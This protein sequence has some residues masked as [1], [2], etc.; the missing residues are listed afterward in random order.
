MITIKLPYKTTDE[1]KAKILE[2][3]KEQNRLFGKAYQFQKTNPT[4]KEMTCYLNQQNSTLDS[5]FIQSAFYEGKAWL[6]ADLETYE[7]KL[8]DWEARKRK[9]ISFKTTKKAA[10][11]NKKLKQ[12]PSLFRVFGGNKLRKDYNLGKIS[13]DQYQKDKLAPISVVGESSK[14]GNRKFCLQIEKSMVIFKP[15]CGLKI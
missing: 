6:K 2:I 10:I 3:Q 9:A 5:W 13:K 14:N 11:K 1:N 4:Q 12:K 8:S 15:L 7:D